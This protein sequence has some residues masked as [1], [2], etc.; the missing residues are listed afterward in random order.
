M[1]RNFVSDKFKYVV[2]A[3]MNGNIKMDHIEIRVRVCRVDSS[4]FGE[5]PEYCFM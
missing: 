3:Y 4:G 2:E 1:I 5:G